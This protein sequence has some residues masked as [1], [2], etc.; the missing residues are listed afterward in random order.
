MSTE[1]PTVNL[2]K[3]CLTPLGEV[4]AHTHAQTLSHSDTLTT[5][6]PTH[7]HSLT[8]TPSLPFAWIAVKQHH[9]YHLP[10]VGK[11]LLPLPARETK[12]QKEEK[13]I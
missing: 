9:C 10:E 11:P 12:A 3:E 2:M 6:L 4:V 8:H 7:S 13:S 5:L 1:L